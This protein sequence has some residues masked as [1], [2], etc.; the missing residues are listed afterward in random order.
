MEIGFSV[1][2]APGSAPLVAINKHISS[3]KTLNSSAGEDVFRLSRDKRAEDEVIGHY[4]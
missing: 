3:K 4:F 1:S 2:S